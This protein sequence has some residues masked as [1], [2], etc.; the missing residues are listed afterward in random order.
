MSW[1]DRFNELCGFS[2][3]LLEKFGIEVPDDV[4]PGVDAALGILKELGQWRERK[5]APHVV[6]ENDLCLIPL[7]FR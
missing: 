3:K 1:L 5:R 7:P 6:I 4:A 2:F